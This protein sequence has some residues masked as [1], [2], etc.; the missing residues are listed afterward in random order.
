M[1]RTIDV[2]RKEVEEW[3]RGNTLKRV[4]SADHAMTQYYIYLGDRMTDPL[5]KGA[6]QAIRTD[7]KCIRGPMEIC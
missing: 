4:E 5:L 6:C 7:G 3:V 1:K 2:P